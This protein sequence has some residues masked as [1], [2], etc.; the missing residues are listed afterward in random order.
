MKALLFIALLNLGTPGEYY[1]GGEPQFTNGIRYYIFGSVAGAAALGPTA[2]SFATCGSVAGLQHTAEAETANYSGP[3]LSCWDGINNLVVQI[4]F[5][6]QAGDPIQNGET[7][8][9]DFVYRAL[10]PRE[11]ASGGSAKTATLTYTQTG[12]ASAECALLTVFIE[13]D[14][15]DGTQPYQVGDA[16]QGFLNWDDS[17][18][19]SGDPIVGG[20]FI[21]I[22]YKEDCYIG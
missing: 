22:P 1:F 18:T 20:L 21:L 17:S 7:V 16:I 4:G 10:A 11:S 2:P 8:V 5:S 6:P 14:K 3:I 13:I 19:Y 9:F 12:G 15:D